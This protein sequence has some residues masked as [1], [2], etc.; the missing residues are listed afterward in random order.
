MCKIFVLQN[1][2]YGDIIRQMSYKSVWDFGREG[3]ANY[4]V[5]KLGEYPTKIRP[6]VISEIV[7]RFS[8]EGDFICD[9]FCGC[10]TVG[11]EAKLQRR[12]SLNFDINPQ[13][14][15]LTKQKFSLLNNKSIAIQTITEL[16]LDM[17][18]R[19]KNTDRKYEKL[20]LRKKIAKWE[21]RKELIKRNGDNYLQT[22]HLVSI[23]DARHLPLSDNTVDAVITDIPYASMI[24]YSGLPGDLS[25]IE[26]YNQFRLELNRAFK[27]IWR[28]LKSGKYCVIF[29]A[30]Y[31]VGASREILPIHA[32]VIQLMRDI[33]FI[34]FDTYIWR[35][36]R[37][38]D[39]RPFGKP[40]Y[41]AMNVHIYILCFYK[42][43]G[44][45][46]KKPNRPIRYRKRLIEKLSKPSSA[47]LQ[48]PLL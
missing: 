10:G 16:V 25:T 46:V 21:E 9:P 38:G 41:Q 30:D 35:Y 14:I 44:I 15:E 3:I 42:P 7:D 47:A 17:E 34:I 8:R 33:G 31:R 36:Y 29:T 28:V 18:R 22:S 4:G 5:H 1:G 39:F 45:E 6:I 43:T 40:P 24:R 13:A 48:A 37:S 26:D 27:E 32:D 2:L 23:A 20:T 12:N 11:V 19:L